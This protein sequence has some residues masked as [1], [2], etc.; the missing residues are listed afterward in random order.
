MTQQIV[1][2]STISTYIYRLLFPVVLLY[3]P[4]HNR[5]VNKGALLLSVLI[6]VSLI[7]L[8]FRYKRVAKVGD[9]LLIGRGTSQIRVPISDIASVE[10]V[11]DFVFIQLPMTYR[12]RASIGQIKLKGSKKREYFFMPTMDYLSVRPESDDVDDLQNA[13]MYNQT[14]STY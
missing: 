1:F 4:F 14:K 11:A 6:A 7:Y 10:R 13:I 9:E 12:G 3:I 8:S 5:P 2:S